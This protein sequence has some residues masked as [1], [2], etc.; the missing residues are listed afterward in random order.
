MS[1]EVGSEVEKRRQPIGH[2]LLSKLPAYSN[3]SLISLG[4]SEK[5]YRVC[6]AEWSLPRLDAGIPTIA[7][8]LLGS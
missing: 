5:Q 1:R 8:V 3:R 6:T 4:N 2:T 7:G